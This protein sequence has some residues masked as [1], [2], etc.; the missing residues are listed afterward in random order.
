MKEIHDKDN[1]GE[2]N[3][4]SLEKDLRIV[5]DHWNKQGNPENTKKLIFSNW[6]HHPYIEKQYINKKISGN[7]E[8]NWVD[9]AKEKYVPE[10]LNLGLSLGCGSGG[11]ERHALRID[12]CE[13]FEAFDVAEELIEI[14]REEA[15]KTGL[16]KRVKYEVCDIN[17]IHLEAEK[18][19]IVMISSAVHHFKELEHV[20]LQVRQ[21]LKPSGFFVINEFIG[22]SQFQWTEDQLLLINQILEAL[23]EK[24]KRSFSS[25]FGEL[26]KTVLRPTLEYM[27][28]LD[29]SEAIRS[30]EIVSLLLDN[31]SVIER[32]DY[33]GTIL[34]ALLDDIVGNFEVDSTE[35]M[36]VL[37][38]LCFMEETLIKNKFISSDFSFLVA[39]NNI[40][41]KT[42]RWHQFRRL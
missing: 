21:A 39:Q 10:K 2:P 24:Y 22:P 27:N 37:K 42:R 33:G 41:H 30:A 5:G 28:A 31:F 26:K 17:S 1:L 36:T 8:K 7:P 29:P 20:F 34:H 6:L 35:D 19:D 38:L 23:S 4:Q 13:R 40:P 14:A 11:L 12:I 32:I 16:N 9:Y 3:L 15:T 18:Y 25:S